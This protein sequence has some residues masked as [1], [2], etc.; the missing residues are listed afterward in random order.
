MADKGV[1]MSRSSNLRLN[2]QLCFALY[3]A[4]NQV[5]R[6]YRPL[7]EAVGLT[8]PQYLVML[9]LWESDDQPAHEIADR[10]QL[11]PAAVSPILGRLEEAGLVVRDQDPDDA[12]T[13]RVRLTPKGAAVELGASRAQLNVVEQTGLCGDELTGLRDDLHDL[14]MRMSVRTS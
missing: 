4:T 14:V 9:V 5:T 13:R 11:S 8:Y 2:D 1:P 6:A 3:A 10:L 12:R 7:L